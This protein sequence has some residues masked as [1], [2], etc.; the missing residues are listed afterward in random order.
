ML[1]ETTCMHHVHFPMLT[2][3]S[4][5]VAGGGGGQAAAPAQQVMRNGGPRNGFGQGPETPAKEA[6]ATSAAMSLNQLLGGQVVF[7]EIKPL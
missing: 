1:S 5:D 7:P 6:A 4:F 3:S 2:A